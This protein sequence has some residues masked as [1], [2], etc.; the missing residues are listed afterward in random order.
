[1]AFIKAELGNTKEP[2]AAPEGEYDLRI[3]KAT[4]KDS[5]AGNKMTEVIL[6]IEG[7][8][9]SPVFHYLIDVTR[10]TAEN[11]RQMRE[12]ELKRFLTVFGI[13]FE[14]GG[15]DD[16]DLQGATGRVFLIQEEDE[17]SV[18]RNKLRLPRLKS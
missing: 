18:T 9:F 15:Y 16:E 4:R 13:K 8:N 14:D 7:G 6:Q 3:A 1:M 11:V 10:D 2:E 17:N 12:L 5:K